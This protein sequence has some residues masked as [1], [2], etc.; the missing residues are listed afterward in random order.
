MEGKEVSGVA[1]HLSKLA[2]LL[3]V[4]GSLTF[5]GK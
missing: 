4:Q 1:S 3:F 5:G 2:S